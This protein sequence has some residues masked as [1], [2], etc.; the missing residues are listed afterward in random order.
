MMNR[1]RAGSVS[2]EAAI[3]W[4]IAVV[5]L[6][7]LIGTIFTVAVDEEMDWAALDIRSD[8]SLHAGFYHA[9]SFP[10]LQKVIQT[11]DADYVQTKVLKEKNWGAL[12]SAHYH[13]TQS[14]CEMFE[15]H[16]SYHYRFPSLIK[17][18]NIILPVVAALYSDGVDFKETTVYITNYGKRYHTSNCY[19]LRK[20][21]IGISLDEAK[22]KGYGPCKHCGGKK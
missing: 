5:V 20:S 4:T 15:G 8:I 7:T 19:H 10:V 11:I 14:S 17:E 21:K 22:E 9:P 16:L 1:K 12:V 6:G 13:V 3:S 2:I 18:E